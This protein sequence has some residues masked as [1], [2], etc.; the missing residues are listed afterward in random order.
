MTQPSSE[1]IQTVQPSTV[2]LPPA[3]TTALPI[4][5]PAIVEPVAAP[6]IDPKTQNLNLAQLRQAVLEQTGLDQDDLDSL[7][8]LDSA[9]LH[10]IPFAVGAIFPGTNVTQDDKGN[11]VPAPPEKQQYIFAMFVGDIDDPDGRYVEGDV[12]VY[13]L[14]MVVTSPKALEWRTFTLNRTITSHFCEKM[15]QEAFVAEVASE[16]VE[17][18]DAANPSDPD[19]E[20]LQTATP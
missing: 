1:Q 19:E 12:R 20:D 16:Y 10:G 17:A 11:V 18:F 5:P 9:E 8:K 6:T 14:P 13:T 4:F 2:V 3:T 15:N 7:K